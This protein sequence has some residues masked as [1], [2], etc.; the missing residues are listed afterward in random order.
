MTDCLERL[1]IIDHL[2]TRHDRL[3]DKLMIDH[4][5]RL[6]MIDRLDRLNMISH[7][8][9]FIM[10]GQLWLTV[11]T[12]NMID[13]PDKLDM[14]DHLVRLNLINRLDRIDMIDCL[15]RLHFRW[16]PITQKD[17]KIKSGTDRWTDGPTDI[18]SR[19]RD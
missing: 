8:Y 18:E 16:S 14:V 3:L 1:D 5:D 6:D 2:V 7:I 10:I 17:K 15:D 12:L 19:A 13:H 11:L 9:R 4:L